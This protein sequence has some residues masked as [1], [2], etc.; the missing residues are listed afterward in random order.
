MPPANPLDPLPSPPPSISLTTLPITGLLVDIYGLAELPP[1]ATQISC[2]WLHHPRSRRKEDMAHFARHAVAAFNQSVSA[3]NSS[4][5][6]IALAFDQRNHGSRLVDDR[7]NGAW[8][9]GNER[10]AQDMFGV[11]AGTVSDQERLIDAVGG[12]LFHDERDKRRI[13]RH[14]VLGVS[15]GGHSAWQSMFLDQR[16]VAA[17]VVIGCP[18]FEYLMRD[19]ARLSKLVT[20]SAGDAGAS[21]AGSRDFPPALV[22]ACKKLDPKGVLFGSSAVPAPGATSEAERARL[23]TVL[24][25]RVKGKQF[26]VCS[27]GDDKLVPYRC[28]QPFMDWFK[29]AAR[30]WYADGGVYVEDNVY[31]GVGHAFSS[32]MVRDAI[33]FVVNVVRGEENVP[34]GGEGDHQASKI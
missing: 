5:G 13:D 3:S 23:R 31:A 19:R 24:D 10:H 34:R 14:L 25:E 2:L 15:L 28:S 27:G 32:E 8:R 17:V 33:R 16:V 11:I 1:T 4:R 18:D 30:T 9:E 6:L 26:L 12:Y 21:F 20:Y 29:D 22:E 7:A